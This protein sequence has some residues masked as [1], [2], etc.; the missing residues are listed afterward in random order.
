MIITFA[1]AIY[2]NDENHTEL[3]SLVI[4]NEKIRRRHY[5]FVLLYMHLQRKTKMIYGKK[6]P[7]Y[8]VWDCMCL[9][10]I[11]N[12][13]KQCSQLITCPLSFYKYVFSFPL[14]PLCFLF[15]CFLFNFT[16]PFIYS[17]ALSLLII[18]T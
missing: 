9:S 11:H 17:L 8:I 3:L 4:G 12:T 7:P 16:V 13:K 14:N 18:K 5:F 6:A 2:H 10:S 15:L 1:Y